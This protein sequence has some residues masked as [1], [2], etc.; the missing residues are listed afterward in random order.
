MDSSKYL[1][2]NKEEL[3]NEF[4]SDILCDRSVDEKL[5]QEL[6]ESKRYFED[7]EFRAFVDTGRAM[8]Y[9]RNDDFLRVT[10]LCTQLIERVTALEMWQL[11]SFNLN[12]IGNAYFII[13]TYER[14]LEYYR[15]VIRVE[16]VHGLNEMTSNAY[17]N[18]AII[19]LNFSDY[20]RAYEYF[21]MAIHKLE[22]G[23]QDI[24]RYASKRMFIYGYLVQTLCELGRAYDAPKYIKKMDETDLSELTDSARSLYHGARMVYGF[25]S[26]DYEAAKQDYLKAK[27]KTGSGGKLA[28]VALIN[29]FI[30]LCDRFHLDPEFYKDEMLEIEAM[31]KTGSIRANMQIYAQ[32]RRY[33]ER[34]GDEARYH[35]ATEEYIHFLESNIEDIRKR[36]RGSLQIVE[37]LI[38][39]SENLVDV[40]TKNTELKLIAE[41]AVRHKNMLQDT[42]QRI[43]MINDLGRRVTS[44]LK[45]D[46]V[47]DRIYQDLKRNMPVDSF[48]LMVAE[49]EQNRLR[50]VAYYENDEIKE[51]I[52]IAIDD[53]NSL[54]AECYRSD[55][56]ICS[57]DLTKDP[58]FSTRHLVKYGDAPDPSSVMFLPLSVGDQ[59][60]GAFSIQYRSQ[61]TYTEQHISFLEALN[62]YLAI[63]LNNAVRS[64]RLESEIES[65]LATQEELE[66]A[67]QRLSRLSSLDG[68]TR[69]GNRRDFEKR[70]PEMLS[71]SKKQGSPI[72]LFMIDIDNFKLYNDTYG[73]LEGDEVLRSVARIIQQ[74][75]DTVG[76][77]SARFGGEEFIGAC[78][79]LDSEQS[80]MLADRIRQQVYDLAI[81]NR[82]APIGQLSIS[83]G[84]AAAEQADATKKREMIRWADASLYHAKHTGKN[85]VVLK[86]I[87]QGETLFDE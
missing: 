41:E 33:Y 53:P 77:I 42:Y 50:S 68:L 63:A 3:Y 13:S 22:K 82:L 51:E 75:L 71:R 35:D 54:F 87:R 66:V 57:G 2:M 23:S 45:I 67:N 62:P 65:H 73:H 15:K 47:V 39:E 10:T 84:V 16:E 55:R 83:V 34:I 52:C 40:T 19:Y 78:L 80:E 29:D 46:K 38:Q 1:S 85:K 9:A 24:P 48:V 43:D 86:E 79:G 81:E 74:H 49:P 70:I 18:I 20:D 36:Q 64:W 58:R 17:S 4:F 11:L 59:V 30:V 37:D 56:I 7:Y 25:Y 61:D 12:L 8:V 60:I 6:S 44:S 14:A 5:I 72:A 26:G 32:L 27:E 28:L 76:G 69:I 31:Q 21:V